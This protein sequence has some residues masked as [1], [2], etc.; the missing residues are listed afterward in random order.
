MTEAEWLACTDP[1][2]MLEAMPGTTSAR[3]LRLFACACCRHFCA[4]IDDEQF[5]QAVETADRFADGRGTKAA[6]KRARQSVRAVRHRLPTEQ[7]K[8]SVEWVALWLA[9]VTASENAFGGVVH[10]IQRLGSEG[11]LRPDERPAADLLLRCIFGNPFVT[12]ALDPIWKTSD[13]VSLAHT[14]Y[15]TSAFDRLSSLA[16]ALRDAGCDNNDILS[17]CDNNGPH[18]RGCWV[19]DLLLS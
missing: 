4:W 5:L 3:K 2:E 12:V 15:D 16:V 13:V 18:A 10:E 17:H 14:I 11:L 19:V 1:V 6:L 9:E 7:G 8:A